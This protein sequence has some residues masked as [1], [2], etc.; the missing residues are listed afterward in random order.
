MGALGRPSD[1]ALQWLRKTDF[2]V[3]SNVSQQALLDVDGDEDLELVLVRG[4][5]PGSL[6]NVPPYCSGTPAPTVV[7]RFDH[8][9]QSFVAAPELLVPDDLQVIA[10]AADPVVA[11]LTGDGRLDLLVSTS[12]IDNHF[13]DGVYG[14]DPERRRVDWTST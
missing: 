4:C 3:P 7:L 10:T 11:D 2:T 6:R 9:T 14:G 13:G 12:G 8:A 1:P 5:P